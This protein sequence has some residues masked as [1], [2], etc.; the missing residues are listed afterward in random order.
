VEVGGAAT[1]SV[2]EKL[3]HQRASVGSSFDGHADIVPRAERR[4]SRYC[5]GMGKDA[6]KVVQVGC[7]GM[8]QGWVESAAGTEGLQIVGLVDLDRSAAQR[9][10]ERFKLP[11]GVVYGSL[12]EALAATGAEVVFDVTVPKAH[13]A[14]VVEALNS[15]R[16]VLGEKPMSDTLESARR[17]VAAANRTGKIYAVTQTQRYRAPI[18]ALRSFLSS[19]AIGGVQE[20]HADF[21]IGAH[22]GGFRDQMDYPL[23]LDM[24]IH[25]F[26]AARFLTGTDP[27]SV[28]C[29]SFNPARS[30]YRG[31]ASAVVIF[32]MTDGIVFCYRGSWCAQGERTDWHGQ[33]RILGSKG[34][35]GWDGDMKF[36]AEAIVPDS[37]PAFFTPTKKL[38]VPVAAMGAERHAGAMRE[39]VAALREGRAP[40]T[41]CQDNIKSLAMVMAAV[42]SAKSG[43]KVA[44]RW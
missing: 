30:W 44:V 31:D 39:F 11:A 24:S 2:I 16:H 28:Y 7:G 5:V 20:A 42:E 22:F 34:S 4:F 8:G 23:I 26:D 9:T 43:K 36:N 29:H 33:W 12:K 18:R 37:A 41:N 3:V 13:E 19:G 27:V 38:E 21:F 10:A 40:E 32:E 14:V 35:V 15:G 6:F 1:D 25:T 17:M